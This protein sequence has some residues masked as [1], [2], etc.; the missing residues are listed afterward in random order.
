MEI[1]DDDKYL[2]PKVSL[3]VDLVSIAILV[4]IDSFVGCHWGVG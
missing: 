1:N 3:V 2:N 4:E